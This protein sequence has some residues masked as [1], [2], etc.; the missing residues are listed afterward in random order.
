VG[1]IGG[2]YDYWLLEGNECFAAG[3]FPNN[4]I[5]SGSAPNTSFTFLNISRTLQQ[6]V[7]RPLSLFSEKTSDCGTLVH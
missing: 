5:Q 3:G 1:N 7:A 4:P 6:I 2:E